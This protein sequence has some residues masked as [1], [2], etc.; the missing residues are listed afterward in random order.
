MKYL[1]I[2]LAVATLILN[3]LL[4]QNSDKGMPANYLFNALYATLFLIGGIYGL[5]KTNAFSKK[6]P[7]LGKTFLYFG[8]AMAFYALGLFVWVYYNL[9]LRVSIPYPSFADVFFVLFYPTA[10]MGSHY[11]I[12]YLKSRVKVGT[13]VQGSLFFVVFFSIIYFFLTQTSLIDRTSVEGAILD[14]LY[15]LGDA[16]LAALGVTILVA[17]RGLNNFKSLL[18]FTFGFIT[19]ALADT[20]FSYLSSH[21]LY[22]NGDISDTLFAFSGFLISW[23][24]IT[25]KPRA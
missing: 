1:L 6:D 5:I 25:L 22:W 7:D 15:P 4:F 21:N 19:L 8:I 24:L 13:M 23:G 18:F 14:I 17:E 3:F 2:V 10:I 9:I 20:L 16:S 12:K 11:L